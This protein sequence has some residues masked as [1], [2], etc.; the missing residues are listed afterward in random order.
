MMPKYMDIIV[1]K[2]VV[3]VQQDIDCMIFTNVY[4]AEEFNANG[5]LKIGNFSH[6]FF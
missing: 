5:N 2:T 1:I 4:R 6:F 3:A